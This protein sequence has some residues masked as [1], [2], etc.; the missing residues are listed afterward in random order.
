MA[1]VCLNL[2][3]HGNADG[4]FCYCHGLSNQILD[5]SDLK[6]EDI[7]KVIDFLENSSELLDRPV[8]DN[9]KV[10]NIISYL[11]KNFKI[12]EQDKLFKI[13]LFMRMHRSCGLK[14]E[15]LTIES[16]ELDV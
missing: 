1:K 12:F 7:D 11:Y 15:L 8:I 4:E 6:N 16:E 10:T 14:L 13:Q 9:N 5:F 3:C 2:G